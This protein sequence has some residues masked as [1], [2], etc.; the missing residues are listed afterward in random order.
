MEGLF[1]MGPNQSNFP[2][3]QMRSSLSFFCKLRDSR[4]EDSFL[5][6]LKPAV[7]FVMVK[8][9]S[10]YS[11]GGFEGLVFRVLRKNEMLVSKEKIKKTAFSM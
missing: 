6:P 5:S 9:S 10:S 11:L 8:T 1:A 7:V 3:E 2:P 4:E